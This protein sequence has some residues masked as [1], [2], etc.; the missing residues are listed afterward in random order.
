MSKSNWG[1]TSW[2]NDFKRYTKEWIETSNCTV[3]LVDNPV[4]VKAGDMTDDLDNAPSKCLRTKDAS[5][6]VY[7]R[8]TVAPSPEIGWMRSLLAENPELGDRVEMVSF[9]DL[10]CWDGKCHSHVHN[11]PV[12]GDCSHYTNV[13]VAYATNYMMARC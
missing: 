6:C 10:V 11:V 8:W 12:Y 9:N 2:E 7:N 13:Y 3:V 1:K 4:W 5:Q